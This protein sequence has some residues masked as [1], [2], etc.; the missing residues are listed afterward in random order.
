METKK[1]K[2]I[3]QQL[4]CEQCDYITYKKS[5]FN[6]HLSTRKHLENSLETIGDKKVSEIISH[7]NCCH[8]NYTT[9]IKANYDKHLLTDKHKKNFCEKE[10]EQEIRHICLQCYK[11]Y[12]NYRG[13]WKH[14]KTCRETKVSPTTPSFKNKITL[15]NPFEKEEL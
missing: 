10:P 2:N 6:K 4:C 7:Y 9:K 3:S 11:E 8:C 13:L 14:K 5:D 12:M 15:I 1:Y